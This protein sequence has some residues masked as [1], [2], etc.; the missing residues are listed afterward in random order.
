MGPTTPVQ[1]REPTD[2]DSIKKHADY[3]HNLRLQADRAILRATQLQ[4]GTVP[5]FDA[6][7]ARQTPTPATRIKAVPGS[8]STHGVEAW[9]TLRAQ[10]AASKLRVA[11]LRAKVAAADADL[12]RS[13]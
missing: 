4:D 6:P 1:L 13:E 11:A 5:L 7:S 9:R 3:A 10:I 8:T 2:T 12:A